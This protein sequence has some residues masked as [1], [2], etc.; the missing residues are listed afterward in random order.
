M[1]HQSQQHGL[2]PL[3]AG[4]S[5]QTLGLQYML[6][7]TSVLI[8]YQQGGLFRLKYDSRTYKYRTGLNPLS[9]G[10]SFQTKYLLLAKQD[11]LGLNPLSAGRSFQT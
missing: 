4:R 5:F 2:N 11:Q 3:S 10:R 1:R 9:A 7:L 6:R 8:P